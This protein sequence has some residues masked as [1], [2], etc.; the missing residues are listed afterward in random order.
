MIRIN[1]HP[2][3]AQKKVRAGQ[4]QLVLFLAVL[5]A[6]VVVMGLLLSLQSARIDEKQQE[7]TMIKSRVEQLKREVGDFDRLKKQ[8]NLLQ[9]QRDTINDLHK[10]RS[11][12]VAMMRE[13]SDILTKGKG[14][15]VDEA[16][17]E[18]LLRR[19]PNAGFNPR[20]NPHHLWVTGFSEKGGNLK[21]SGRAKDYDDVA[22]FTKRISLSRHFTS[23][24]LERNDQVFD[25]KLRLKVVRF[26]LR[27]RVAY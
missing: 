25:S 23:D 14:P 2:V 3:R 12:P 18:E 26:S 6:E 11:G 9:R 1:L 10:K 21:I 20:W 7:L 17:Y 19:D 4:R 8:R 5:L 27:C 22:E 24:F 13:L 15:T 16:S